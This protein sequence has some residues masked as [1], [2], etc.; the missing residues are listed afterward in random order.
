MIG[1]ICLD[2]RSQ[3]YKNWNLCLVFFATNS[4]FKGSPIKS[5]VS[6]FLNLFFLTVLCLWVLFL[7]L[8]EALWFS[9]FM[10]RRRVLEKSFFNHFLT[11]CW[12]RSWKVWKILE[13]FGCWT[14]LNSGAKRECVFFILLF[15]RDWENEMRKNFC[16]RANFSVHLQ[17][18]KTVFI[19][20]FLFKSFGYDSFLFYGNFDNGLNI[21]CNSYEF[22]TNLHVF[23]LF[24]WILG[25]F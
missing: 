10:T 18:F 12:S 3:R 21:S 16:K 1:F 2:S 13:W 14:K 6:S 19:Y 9:V 20:F 23:Q 4:P 5:R 22:Y 24:C 8:E 17:L 11:K 25:E 7:R 15:S